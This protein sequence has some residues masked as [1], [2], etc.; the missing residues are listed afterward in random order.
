MTA[1]LHAI[2]RWCKSIHYIP[3]SSSP[4]PPINLLSFHALFS[5][6][7]YDEPFSCV[8]IIESNHQYQFSVQYKISLTSFIWPFQ[9]W[10]RQREWESFK[11]N[12]VSEVDILKNGQRLFRHN[13][14]CFR[15]F[16]EMNCSFHINICNQIVLR[17]CAL[18]SVKFTHF[19]VHPILSMN[20]IFFFEPLKKV[21]LVIASFISTHRHALVMNNEHRR[22]TIEPSRYL[23][24]RRFSFPFSAFVFVL[25]SHFFFLLSFWNLD[26]RV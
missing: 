9:K 10:N 14:E 20:E 5:R 23:R 4:S 17:F 25:R 8:F 2:K 11:K 24:F 26:A 21:D 15:L 13:V 3:S 7:Y 6:L 22:I 16:C 18:I 1:I 12:C 19:T